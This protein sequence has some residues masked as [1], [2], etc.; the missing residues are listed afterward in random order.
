MTLF[1]DYEA[2]NDFGVDLKNTS[3]CYFYS[4]LIRNDYFLFPDFDK[5]AISN[6]IYSYIDLMT[7]IEHFH[8]SLF[9]IGKI[10][11]VDKI[12]YQIDKNNFLYYEND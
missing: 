6:K 7:S 3:I 10:S 9:D 12:S 2:K 8:S 11:I 5:M 1:V 4:I